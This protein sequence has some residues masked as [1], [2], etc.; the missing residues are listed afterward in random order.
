MKSA[1]KSEE[2]N[3]WIEI[4]MRDQRNMVELTGNVKGPFDYG[5]D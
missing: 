3:S 5:D 2:K 4:L 1:T